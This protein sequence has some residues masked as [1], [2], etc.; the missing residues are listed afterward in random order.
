MAGDVLKL[1]RSVEEFISDN[2]KSQAIV[3]RWLAAQARD[4]KALVDLVY[5]DD[6]SEAFSNMLVE[7]RKAE[8]KA[9]KDSI[10]KELNNLEAEEAKIGS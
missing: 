8:L 9:Q 7:F 5:K 1:V 3:Y 10:L 4:F 2:S 6:K